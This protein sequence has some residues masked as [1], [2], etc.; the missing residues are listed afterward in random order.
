MKQAAESTTSPYIFLLATGIAFVSF[1][2]TV[3][4]SEETSLADKAHDVLR[5]IETR[6]QFHYCWG[7]SVGVSFPPH[8]LEES[9][10]HIHTINEHPLEAGMV[11]HLP[12][13]MRV[14]GKYASGTSRTIVITQDGAKALTGDPAL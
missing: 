1:I 7:Y 12:L 5:P 11:F 8:W 14:L 4:A 6:I 10:F 9:M 2:T 3:A 13:T